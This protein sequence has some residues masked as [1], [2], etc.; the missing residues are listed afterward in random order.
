MKGVKVLKKTIT[1]FLTLFLAVILSTTSLFAAN[2][3]VDAHNGNDSND[4]KTT[5]SP[6]K[7]CPGMSL[8][9]DKAASVSLSP[10]DIV[11][12]KMGAVWRDMLTINTS[13]SKDKPITFAAKLDWGTGDNPKILSS[14][15]VS[16]WTEIDTTHHIWRAT[17]SGK[18]SSFGMLNSTSTARVDTYGSFNPGFSN[19]TDQYFRG[20]TGDSYVYFKNNAG[21][22]GTREVGVRPYGI[23]GNGKN[24]ITVDGIDVYGPL[25]T[26]PSDPM[27][28]KHALSKK[29][30]PISFRNSN[31]VTVKNCS[32]GLANSVGIGFWEWG[33][34]SVIEDCSITDT[35]GGAWWNVCASTHRISRC[36]ITNIALR[37]GDTGDKDMIGAF[38]TDD[39]IVEDCYLDTS[40]HANYDENGNGITFSDCNG[41]II[42]RNYIKNAAH[43][44]ILVGGN[45]TAGS[46]GV[47]IYNN[48]IDSWGRLTGANRMWYDGII[49]G[50]GSTAASTYGNVLVYNNLF[51]NGANYTTLWDEE[52][53]TRGNVG[54]AGI[55]ILNNKFGDVKVINNLFHNNDS[56]YEFTWDVS[57]Y[58]GTR[59][60]SYNFF[61]QME[62]F[63]PLLII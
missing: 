52:G 21:N 26:H 22:P 58:T 38:R 48:I 33:T 11:Y 5:N 49:I 36:H 45:N 60:I 54:N 7:Y 23:F 61:C 43:T 31:Y 62:V 55:R 28:E 39:I 6:W 34:N 1:G 2:Y 42:R 46:Y 44:G 20:D 47:Q 9:T 59:D 37:Y 25:G 24:Y 16:S 32:V 3:Y 4:G 12:F 19:W 56:I 40:G 15:Q 18:T 35:W 57:Q 41:Q 30:G 50:A 29:R 14:E 51:I 53:N 13:G 27:F 8:A 63:L 10:G 17:V